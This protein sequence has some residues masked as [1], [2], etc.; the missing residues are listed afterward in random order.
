VSTLAA[1]TPELHAAL[2]AGLDR[3]IARLRDR[4]GSL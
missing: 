2:V 3:G 1:C 4:L